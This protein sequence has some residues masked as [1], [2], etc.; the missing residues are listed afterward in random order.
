MRV[1][2][3][4]RAEAETMLFEGGLRIFATVDMNIQ[5]HLEEY[6]STSAN[7]PSVSNEEFPQSAFVVLDHHGKILGLVG[8]VGEKTGNR[9][10]NRATMARRHP[11]SS[12][13]PISVYANAFEFNQA[14]WS[15]LVDDF[16]INPDAPQSQWWPRNFYGYYM[17]MVT[18]DLAM[19]RSI[20][21]IPV[22]L[23]QQVGWQT[24]FDFMY[25][26]L[27]MS[28]SL[29]E[30]QVIGD[31]V[32]SDI[33]VAPLALGALTHGLTPLEMAGAYQIFAN[34]GWFTRPFAYTEVLDADGR[35]ILRADTEPRRVLSPDTAEVMRRLLERAVHGPRA[36]GTRAAIPGMPTAGK[37]GTSDNDV[38]QWFI[39]FT[40]YY[41]GMVWLGYDSPTTF[42]RH[43]NVVANTIWYR[44]L[45]YPPPIIFHDI[46]SRVHE[47]Y[48][49]KP[50]WES[51][52]VDSHMYCLNSGR[53]AGPNCTNLGTGWFKRSFLPPVCNG[54]YFSPEGAQRDTGAANDPAPPAEAPPGLLLPPAD[55]EA[56]APPGSVIAIPVDYVTAAEPDY[57]TA[58]ADY[59]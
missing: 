53:L 51:G 28:G 13:K 1:R 16:P 24:I 7:F 27:Q 46:M 25:Y 21:T 48:E 9:I 42:D 5:M 44:G 35:V 49:H 20:N 2:G 29:V 26:D 22:K 39:G 50:F 52:M 32:F 54:F 31:R 36:T 33:D 43:G 47:G 34:G 15:M 19:Q 18:V 59:G 17:R 3:L 57:I 40:P 56:T 4:D 14:Y 8:G 38:D 30:R 41:I 11:G 6:Y 45:P 12:I 10:F 23:G 37:T 58:I 55:E